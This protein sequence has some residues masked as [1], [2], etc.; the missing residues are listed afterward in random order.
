MLTTMAIVS[1]MNADKLDYHWQ[2]DTPQGHMY[3]AYFDGIWLIDM[4]TDEKIDRI[5]DSW[6]SAHC[7]PTPTAT[8]R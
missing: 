1:K 8:Q 4:A 2:P 3:V 7:N 5:G 6:M